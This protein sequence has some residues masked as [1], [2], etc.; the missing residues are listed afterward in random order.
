MDK[1]KLIMSLSTIIMVAVVV[2]G[3]TGAFFSD[4]ETSTG[5]TFTA[6]AIDLKIDNHCFY[7]GDD[8]ACTSNWML[9]DLVPTSDKFFN[10]SDVKPGD[11]GVNIISLHIINNDAW[12]CLNI[13]NKQDNDN[14]LTEPEDV[15]DDTPG[16]GEGELS[17]FLST[18]TWWDTDQNGAF[19]TG[20][21][22]ID[23]GDLGSVDMWPLA[24]A[25]H[26]PAITGGQTKYL[27]LAWCVGMWA[28]T[29]VA[30]QPFV[31]NGSEMDNITQTDSF[32]ADIS[33]YVEQSRNNAGFLCTNQ[34]SDEPPVTA[35]DADGDG[36]ADSQDN[37]PIDANP[38]QL[39]T[40]G[41]GLGDTCDPTPNGEDV[42]AD[43]DGV[44]DAQDNCPT[45][46]NPNQTD[47]NGDGIGNACTP[48]LFF[49]EYVEGSS[50][51]KALEIYNPTGSGIN[52]SSYTIK[53]YTNGNPSP[54][55]NLVLP[56]IVLAAG[57]VYVICNQNAGASLVGTGMCNFYTSAD[58][59]TFNGNDA[60]ALQKGSTVLDVIGQIGFDPG[61]EWGTSPTSTENNTLVRKC[62]IGYGD[63]VGGDLFDPAFEWNGF[64]Q[65]TF[66][67]L[68]SH[69]HPCL[70]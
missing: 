40:D 42:D 7:N 13:G 17:G 47:F 26:L 3:A 54:G 27:G 30:G 53:K 52:L 39:N 36:I 22:Q 6:G 16:V 55:A 69:T 23:N 33:F 68:G 2:I 70:P 9:K 31:C 63:D 44:A 10:F 58:A 60:I 32:T 25:G 19:D 48:D 64:A 20:E 12:A 66:S 62:N 1:K 37:C 4:T 21:G 29:P 49:S 8:Q 15:V 41:D 11:S 61:T 46:Y 51:N 28:N 56:N 65:D 67:N 43:G 38:D 57:N 59:I 18:F 24:D 14:G 34:P 50:L 5:N 45:V 35:P